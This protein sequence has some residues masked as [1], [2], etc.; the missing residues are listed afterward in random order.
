MKSKYILFII[1][2]VILIAININVYAGEFLEPY[3]PTKEELGGKIS[4]P[5]REGGDDNYTEIYTYEELYS[6]LEDLSIEYRS[7]LEEYHSAEQN[8]QEQLKELQRDYDELLI[9]TENLEEQSDNNNLATITIIVIGI[10]AVIVVL[11]NVSKMRKNTY[12]NEGVF[13]MEEK[14]VR[15]IKKKESRQTR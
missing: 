11:Y 1:I 12:R 10:I 7:L 9:Q 4:I 14:H 5:N 13:Y 6:V 15:N 2:F 8:Y 3:T